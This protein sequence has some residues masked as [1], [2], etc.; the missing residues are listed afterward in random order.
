MGRLSTT[1]KK[2][3]FIGV[4]RSDVYATVCKSHQNCKILLLHRNYFIVRL[5]KPVSKPRL[6]KTEAAVKS[7]EPKTQSTYCCFGAKKNRKIFHIKMWTSFIFK[8][9]IYDHVKFPTQ[10]HK[11]TVNQECSC[12]LNTKRQRSFC[13]VCLNG[14]QTLELYQQCLCFSSCRSAVFCI[15][16]AEILMT[17]RVLRKTNTFNSISRLRQ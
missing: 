12:F 1:G 17:R 6:L 9:E 10:D 8:S 16:S 14:F 5:L 4:H 13:L 11:P 15:C 3:G 7:Q 2:G